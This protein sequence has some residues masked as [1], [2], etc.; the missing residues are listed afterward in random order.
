MIYSATLEY[1]ARSKPIDILPKSYIAMA[2]YYNLY[3]IPCK[4]NT[5]QWLTL[6]LTTEQQGIFRRDRL[7]KIKASCFLTRI[8]TR[9][10]HF[11]H[12][13]LQVLAL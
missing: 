6:Q 10:T 11:P 3:G 2:L 5:D 4:T 7:T 9:T 13:N 12:P 1:S 8:R